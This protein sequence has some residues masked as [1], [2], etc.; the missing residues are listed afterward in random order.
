[1]QPKKFYQVNLILIL[2]GRSGTIKFEFQT[3]NRFHPNVHTIFDYNQHHLLKY[4]L[5]GER[6]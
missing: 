4:P 3:T 6:S 2:W 1:M 5:L